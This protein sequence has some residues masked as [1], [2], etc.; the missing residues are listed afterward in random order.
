MPAQ[1]ESVRTLLTKLGSGDWQADISACTG[2]SCSDP[3]LTTEFYAG[4]RD[5]L[6]TRL[7][8]LDSRGVDLFATSGLRLEKLLVLLGDTLRQEISYPVSKSDLATWMRAYFATHAVYTSRSSN[9][10]QRDLGSFSKKLRT[11]LPVFTEDVTVTSKESDHFTAAGVYALPGKAFTVTRTGSGT[12]PVWVAVNTI[13]SGSTDEFD[14][15]AYTRPKFLASQWIQLSA[16]QPLRLSSPYGGP[17]QIKVKGTGVG[18]AKQTASVRFDNVGKHAVW[19]GADTTAAFTAALAAGDYDWAEYVTDGF[20]IHSKVDR[21]RETLANPRHTTPEALAE[22]TYKYFYQ[23][24]FN[25]AGFTGEGLSLNPKVAALC[26]AN[27]WDCTDPTVHGMFSV[28]HFNADQ[29]TCGYGCSGNPYDAWW[30]FDPL[31]WG[32][33]HEVGHN[34]QRSRMHIEGATGEASNNI[35][36]S[37]NA[38]GWNKDN[39][40]DQLRDGHTAPQREVFTMLN[41]AQNTADPKATVKQ[42]LWVDGGSRER[43]EFY[44]QLA[45]QAYYLPDF[46]DGGWDIMT[47]LYLADRIY[48]KALANDTTWAAQRD[49][50]GMGA[51]TRSAASAISS[52]DWMLLMT[53]H[54]TGKDQRPVFDLWGITTS[55]AASAQLDARA[56]PAAEKRFYVMPQDAAG[57]YLAAY[58]PVGSVLVTGQATLP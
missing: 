25:L 31:G 53:S 4:A 18:V 39:P 30:A 12:N 47:G 24:I 42:A 37:R 34:L 3:V 2:H 38:Y 40:D 49:S 57:N 35:F 29:A 14:A 50:L 52:N 11:D 51:Y 5:Y 8:D 21:L 19:K 20:Q 13:R 23:S 27:G 41:D 46:G 10:A 43:L 28:T 36:P 32:D 1:I 22:T 9:T 17:L 55:A 44:R 6:K 48:G 58:D 54:L 33:G 16:N 45:W 56:L 26:V 7:A 15:G